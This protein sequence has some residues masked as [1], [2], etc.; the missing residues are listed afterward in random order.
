MDAADGTADKDRPTGDKP[1]RRWPRRVVAGATAALVAAVAGV[2]WAYPIAA[3]AVC[4]DCY[5]LEKVAPD[6]YVDGDATPE[7][8]RQMVDVIAAARQRVG[9]FYGE[10]RSSPRF[11]IC[12]SAGC[13]GHLGGGEK[14]Q[15]LRDQATALS[16]G[17]ANVVIA[18]HELTHAEQYRRLGSTYDEVPR[19][20]NEGLAVLI[21]DDPRYLTTKPAG[22]RCPIAYAEALA[23]IRIA[24]TPGE[25]QTGAGQTGEGPAT[26]QAFYRDA[27]CVVD[28]WVATH[29]GPDAVRDLN[30]RLLAGEAFSDVVTPA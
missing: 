1:R 2:V 5:G 23:A 15:T 17:G 13:Y 26:G 30:R 4:P 10:L 16:P 12:L 7:Q 29:G 27:A 11:L 25:A 21:S 28:R 20:F 9:T 24:K 8:R 3:A 22:E 18:S 19:W 14:G 6:L